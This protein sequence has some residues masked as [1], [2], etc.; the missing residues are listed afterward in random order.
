M[1]GPNEWNKKVI[2]LFRANGGKVEEYYPDA[3]LLLLHTLGAKSGKPRINPLACLPDGDEIL[4][5]AS[6]QGRPNNPDWYFN[7]LANPRVSVELGTE[8]FDAL[9]MVTDEPE[10][11]EL[12][13]KMV[14]KYP[15]YAEYQQKT[16][17]PFPVITLVRVR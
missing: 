1:N 16:D 13:V 9:A 17:R 8:K 2:E 12:F 6:K 10:R 14:A 3:T 7:I 4:I 15:N 11:T 5:V